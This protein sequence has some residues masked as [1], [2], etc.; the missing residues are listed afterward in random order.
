MTCTQG[1][2]I[3]AASYGNPQS[4]IYVANSGG[5]ANLNTISVPAS[6]SVPGCKSRCTGQSRYGG[7]IWITGNKL[8]NNF[9]GVSIIYS[10]TD[11][12]PGDNDHDAACATPLGA[13][14][15]TTDPTYYQQGSILETNSADAEVS[16]DSVTTASGT[17][18]YCD[19]FGKSPQN[20][21][22]NDD[23]VKQAPVNGMAVYNMNTGSFS[24]NR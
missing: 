23:E 1:G 13:L 11:R 4:T 19:D 21:P 6:I 3:I 8:M 2:G 20:K 16:G 10:D 18:S 24:R 17:I 12:Y 9:G 5:N 15:E 22:G 14:E 7:H